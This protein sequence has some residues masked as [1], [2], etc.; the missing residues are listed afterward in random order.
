MAKLGLSS[1]PYHLTSEEIKV[2]SARPGNR[3][4]LVWVACRHVIPQIRPLPTATTATNG[5]KQL[6]TAISGYNSSKRLQQQKTATTAT[7]NGYKQ[8]IT[9]SGKLF[10]STEK[11]YLRR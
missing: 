10:C 11:V 5:F 8:L 3:T 7:K 4:W 1:S 2:N 9:E 6:Q